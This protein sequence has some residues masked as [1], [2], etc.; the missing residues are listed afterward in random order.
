[1]STRLSNAHSQR[2]FSTRVRLPIANLPSTSPHIADTR[3][4]VPGKTSLHGNVHTP[5]PSR[6]HPAHAPCRRGGDSPDFGHLEFTT[7]HI[8][9]TCLPPTSCSFEGGCPRR[10][11]LLTIAIPMVGVGVVAV[12]QTSFLQ[13][14]LFSFTYI[15]PGHSACPRC[16]SPVCMVAVHC[17]K[18]AVLLLSAS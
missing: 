2:A 18:P 12:P 11:S 15:L 3:Q 14:H 9:S 4:T 16:T 5:V 6:S 13:S 1:M 8:S 10:N 17:R 7:S